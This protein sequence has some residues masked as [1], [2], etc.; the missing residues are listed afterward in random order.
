MELR[1][2]PQSQF[3]VIAHVGWGMATDTDLMASEFN[4]R[5][6]SRQEVGGADESAPHSTKRPRS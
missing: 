3:N 6:T 5:G 2:D 1:L 4:E